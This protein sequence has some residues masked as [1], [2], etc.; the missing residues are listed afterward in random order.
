MRPRQALRGIHLQVQRGEVFGFIGPNGAGKSTTIKIL[1]GL[2]RPGKGQVSL[3][4]GSPQDPRCRQRMGYLPEQPY[5]YDYLSGWELLEFY[6]ALYGLR[7]KELR[8]RMEWSLELVHAAQDW[9]HRRLRTYSKGMLQ[10]VGLAQAILSRPELLILDEPMSGLD[11]LGRRD[12]RHAIQ[13]LNQSGTTIFYS[14][15]VLADV[16]QISHRVAMIVDG[17]IVQEGSVAEIT[18]G[19]SAEFSALVETPLPRLPAGVRPGQHPREY[20]CDSARSR[21]L[22]LQACLD[23]QIGILKLDSSRPSLEDILAKEVAHAES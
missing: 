21:D 16:E 18:A 4:G 7:G 10:R 15:H 2:L 3:L 14:S 9:I 6:G 23:Q 1:T 13:N 12:V 8:Q 19:N 20:R 5:F 22:L 17:R 11:P